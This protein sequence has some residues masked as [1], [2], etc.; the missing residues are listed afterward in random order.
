MVTHRICKYIYFDL[1]C[2]TGRE[3]KGIKQIQLGGGKTI[4]SLSYVSSFQQCRHKLWSHFF[5][6]GLSGK[7]YRYRKDRES[8]FENRC[9]F[10]HEKQMV[11]TR[12]QSAWHNH[13]Q[14]THCMVRSS[15]MRT[16]AKTENLENTGQFL[17]LQLSI[18]KFGG[19]ATKEGKR[20]HWLLA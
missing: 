18:R 14:K 3:T 6:F 11:I 10:V 4:Y 9:N 19:N 17:G 15:T 16:W 5:F 13:G 20:L 12:L 7:I 2:S 1:K 8:L